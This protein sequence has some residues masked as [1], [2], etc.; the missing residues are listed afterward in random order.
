M[1]IKLSEL[2]KLIREAHPSVS[3]DRARQALGKF[4]TAI[5]VYKAYADEQLKKGSDKEG[6]LQQDVLDLNDIM[7]QT[8]EELNASDFPSSDLATRISDLDTF[9][10][11]DIPQDIYDWILVQELN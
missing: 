5:D 8:E 4:Q 10:R 9:V 1:K 6:I 11:D 3:S 2:K 7:D